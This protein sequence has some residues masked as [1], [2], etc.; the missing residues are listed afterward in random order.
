MRR[1]RRARRGRCVA[2]DDLARPRISPRSACSIVRAMRLARRISSS[3]RSKARDTEIV[4]SAKPSVVVKIC[5]STILPP[6]AAQAPAMIDSRRGWSGA[7]M[8]ISVTPRKASV[9]TS[10]ASELHFRRHR[11]EQL[12]VSDEVRQID[13]QPIG[14][15]VALR[16]RRRNRGPT[17]RAARGAAPPAPPRPATCGRSP[18]GRRRARLPSPRRACAATGLS[19]RS[20][21]PGRRRGCRR[22]SASAAS[23]SRSSD[24]TIAASASAVRGSAR[25]RPCAMFD[26]VRCCSIS[27]ATRSRIGGRKAEARAEPARDL[28]AGD[29]MVLAPALG[30]I[31]QE[32]GDDRARCGWVIGGSNSLTSGWSSLERAGL[33]LAQHADGAQQVLVDRVVMVHR[34]LHHARR[35]GR[36]RG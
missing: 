29:R 35:R 36:N 16:H 11:V 6:A 27:Q 1:R 25:S 30:D 20:R 17:S 34:E 23:C 4:S 3:S 15:I 28:G 22:R 5:A 18:N 7:T 33:D 9:A 8:V 32:G 10:V 12:G 19:S 26:M 24:C 31:V 14:G 13:L 2:G 21:R